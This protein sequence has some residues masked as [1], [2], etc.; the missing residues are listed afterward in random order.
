M[1][2]VDP[3]NKAVVILQVLFGRV[4]KRPDDFIKQMNESLQGASRLSDLLLEARI[5]RDLII[6]KKNRDLSRQGRS[7]SAE[8][9]SRRTRSPCS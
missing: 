1:R 5:L 3:I 7:G 2:K 8:Y 9:Y 6:Y 4:S